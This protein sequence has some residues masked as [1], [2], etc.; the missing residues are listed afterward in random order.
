MNDMEINRKEYRINNL[1][2]LIAGVFLPLW[3]LFIILICKSY[4][5]GINSELD[6]EQLI[7]IV[8]TIVPLEIMIIIFTT[9]IIVTSEG[10]E[11][12]GTSILYFLW[13]KNKRTVRIKWNDIKDLKSKKE[14]LLKIN[15]TYYIVA[16]NDEAI[17]FSSILQ[18]YK[19]LIEHIENKTN[20]KF[21]SK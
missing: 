6:Y 7:G 21:D 2:L 16:N 18:N 8:L 15:K 19:E 5:T 9:K 13:Y 1:T 11:N 20:L 10:I 4:I 17:L 3:I 12:T 14:F